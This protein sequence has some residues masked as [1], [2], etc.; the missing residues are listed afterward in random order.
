MELQEHYSAERSASSSF[1]LRSHLSRV[2]ECRSRDKPRRSSTRQSN[3]VVRCKQCCASIE[4]TIKGMANPYW[5]GS[6]LWDGEEAAVRSECSAG[7]P[8]FLRVRS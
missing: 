6:D 5:S 4:N 2:R 1:A 7:S 8:A 3:S